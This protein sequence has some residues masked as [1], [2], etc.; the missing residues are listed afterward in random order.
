VKS[1]CL[2]ENKKRTLGKHKHHYADEKLKCADDR[3]PQNLGG[4][5]GVAI[6]AESV[7]LNS[8]VA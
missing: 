6:K 3:M 2:S 5:D 4:K 7:S 8:A 1:P